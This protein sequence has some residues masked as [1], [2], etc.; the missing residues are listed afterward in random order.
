[1]RGPA[2][3]DV[4]QDHA[5]QIL[6][7]AGL[8][9]EGL[10]FKGGTALRKFRAGNAGRFSTDLDFAVSEPGLAELVLETLDG[11]RL[12]DFEFS[13]E[14]TVEGRRANLGVTSPFGELGIG[15]GIDISP[16]L[17]WL[18]AEL[19]SAIL[20]P[21]HA[22]YSFT[23]PPTPIIQVEELI[24]EKLARYRRDS[25]ARD[26]YDLAWF[27]GSV[28]DE[29]LVRRLTAMKVWWDVLRDGLGSRPFDPRAILGPRRP[30]DF[31]AEAIGQ[32][33]DPVDLQ[34]WSDQVRR[35]FV[36]LNDLDADEVLLAQCTLREESLFRRKLAALPGF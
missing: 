8:F 11:S 20:M 6:H 23:L 13:V 10:V 14:V 12:D 2:I 4:A 32:L 36:F 33:T 25:L 17:P 16:T 34:R 3:L 19:R 35:R 9:H 28:F 7:N 24:A 27:H 30:T 5:L 15:A 18:Q 29:R 21:I 1:M 31:R 26:V 22:R